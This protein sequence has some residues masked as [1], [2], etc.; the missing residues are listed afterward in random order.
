MSRVLTRAAIDHQAFET[1]AQMAEILRG[2]APDGAVN[3][4]AASRFV[5]GRS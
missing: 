2:R 4:A 1:V 3:T 5:G